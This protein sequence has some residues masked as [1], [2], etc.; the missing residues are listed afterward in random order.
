MSLDF[1]M[2]S[3]NISVLSLNDFEI[4]SKQEFIKLAPIASIVSNET[5][6]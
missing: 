1:I 4:C 3:L 2:Q 6:I 5:L